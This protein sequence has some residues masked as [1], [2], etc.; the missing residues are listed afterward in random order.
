MTS[1]F[2]A[3]LSIFRPPNKI[4]QNKKNI[5]KKTEIYQSGSVQKI[6]NDTLDFK[7]VL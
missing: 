2:D 1:K 6:I 3:I 5:Q 4:S 7:S